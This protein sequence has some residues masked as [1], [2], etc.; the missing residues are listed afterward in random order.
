MT[1]FDSHYL[2]HYSIIAFFWI[3]L[4]I[5]AVFCMQKLQEIA[6][7][8]RNARN[9]C[10][11]SQFLCKKARISHISCISHHFPHYCKIQKIALMCFLHIAIF[12]IFADV[13]KK[14]HDFFL[15][16]FHFFHAFFHAIFHLFHFS[17][18]AKAIFLHMLNKICNCKELHRMDSHK[19]RNCMELNHMDLQK[20]IKS[21]SNNYMQIHV[22]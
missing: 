3:L 15:A 2:S 4:I 6:I 12:Q 18:L 22:I 1:I 10:D 5:F 8:S 9:Y 14:F 21:N 11:L 20:K 17:T 19:I 13:A 7:I 16:F